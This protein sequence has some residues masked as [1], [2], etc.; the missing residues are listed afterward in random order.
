MRIHRFFGFLALALAACGGASTAPSSAVSTSA[1]SSS[2]PAAA[3]PAWIVASNE[4]A[5]PL[6]EVLTKYAPEQAALYGIDGHDGEIGDLRKGHEARYRA[7]LTRVL[8][9]L[10]EREAREPEPRVKEDLAIMIHYAEEEI[11]WS[12]VHERREVPFHSVTRRVFGNLRALLEDRIP[13]AR[14]QFALSRLRRYAGLEPDTVPMTE[15]ARAETSEALAKPG[16]MPPRKSEVEKA[17]QTNDVLLAGIEKLFQKYGIEGY[18][19]PLE[20]FRKQIAAYSDFLRQTVLPRARTDIRMDPE[21]YAVDLGDYGVDAKPEELIALGHQ[22]FDSIRAEMQEVAA[23]IARARHLPSADYHDVVLA[24]KKEQIAPD[25]V[26]SV[27]QQRLR[28]VEAIIA[29]EH[30]VTLPNRPAR[31]RLGTDAE[32]AAAPAPHMLPPRLIGNTGEEGEFVITTSAPPAPGASPGDTKI[33]DFSYQ[34][35]TWSLVAHEARPGHELQFS[36]LV[37]NGISRARAV[38]AENSANV[39][40]WGLYSEYI[41][42]RYMPAEGRLISLLFRLHR[43]IRVFIDPELQQGKWTPDSARA[44]LQKELLFSPAFANSEVERYTF[45]APGQA[46][47]YYYGFTR[48]LEIRREVERRLGAKFDLQKFDDFVLR[49]GLL[50]PK[51]LREAALREFVGQA[52]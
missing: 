46:T 11:R 17:L 37:E 21:V 12:E 24:L 39:E 26:L 19:E 32:N 42:Y 29:R 50:P 18:R 4:A 45:D 3:T 38:F 1:T 6:F 49:Q 28:D 48:L 30:L 13:P 33:D 20:A 2:S 7:D 51:L 23:E 44:F 43:A 31:I 41:T 35:A 15:L 22:G 9:A 40:G 8:A 25:K 10:R 52:G 47:S 27:Y 14:R 34:A 36:S 16:L 5:Q